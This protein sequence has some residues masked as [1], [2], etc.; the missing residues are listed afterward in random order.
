M[1]EKRR[2]PASKLKERAMSAFVCLGFLAFLGLLVDS[3]L[4]VRQN[5]QAL[6][7]PTTTGRVTSSEVTRFDAMAGDSSY[8]FDVTYEYQVGGRHLRGS[9]SLGVS[10]SVAKKWVE[11]YPPGSSVSVYYDPTDPGR[12]VVWPETQ[13]KE[14]LLMALFIVPLV[15]LGL[16]PLWSWLKKRVCPSSASA[17]GD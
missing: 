6:G 16:V 3:L 13:S 1:Q 5:R 9:S 8:Y 2:R 11:A 10:E 7:W 15:L 4:E 12:S 14:A 17:T